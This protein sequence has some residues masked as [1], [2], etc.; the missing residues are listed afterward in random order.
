MD[1]RS[2]VVIVIVLHSV[3]T[4]GSVAVPVAVSENV[5]GMGTPAS[6]HSLLNSAGERC[7]REHVNN[8]TQTGKIAKGAELTG[9]CSAGAVEHSRI[10]GGVPVGNNA[11]DAITETRRVFLRAPA[12]FIRSTILG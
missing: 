9:K 6:A 5:R 1:C 2:G 7:H 11:I 12:S 8:S 10:I 3:D 4:A